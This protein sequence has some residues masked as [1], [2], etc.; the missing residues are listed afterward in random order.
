MIVCAIYPPAA[1]PCVGLSVA[2]LAFFAGRRSLRRVR[3]PKSP[4]ARPR[5]SIVATAPR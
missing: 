4:A 3:P 5:A 1:W 2:W